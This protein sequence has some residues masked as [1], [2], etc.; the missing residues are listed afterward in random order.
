[1]K[2]HEQHDYPDLRKN[3]VI[4]MIHSLIEIKIYFKKLKMIKVSSY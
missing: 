2:C 1:M 3:F 4:T